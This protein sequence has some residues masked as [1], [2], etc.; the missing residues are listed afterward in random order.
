MGP[1]GAG[2]TSL[3]NVLAGKPGYEVTDGSVAFN[4]ENL[5]EMSP[6][7]RAR[8]GLFLSFQHPVEIPG[9]SNLSFIKTAINEK[10]K[11]HGEDTIDALDFRELANDKAKNIKLDPSF[12]N[13]SLNEGFSGGEKKKN[14]IF[15]LA[16]LEPKLAILDEIDSGLDVDALKIVANTINSIKSDKNA[17]L[18]IT[19]YK[20]LAEYIIPDFVHI[21]SNGK[22][23]RS[24]DK[25]LA[26]EIESKGYESA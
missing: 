16:M 8:K 25:T 1:N 19:H 24:G 12:L 9:L 4:N 23:I 18:I 7:I 22:I 26:E 5:L 21:L 11:H 14:E 2:K 10:R 13:R 6:E 20:R 17:F 3:S 15:Q